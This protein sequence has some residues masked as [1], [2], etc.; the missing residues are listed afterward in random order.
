MHAADFI[1]DLAII[2]AVAG[3][4][5]V[6]F[7]RFKQPVV[8][9]YIVAGVIIG[10]HLPPAK[11]ITD[12]A[13]IKILGEL[14]VVF[15]LFSLGLEFNWRKLRQVGVT[16]F[17]GA[18]TEI[19]LMTWIGYEI[20]RYFEWQPIDALFLGAMLS[21]SSTTITVKAL[22]EL[23][24]KRERFAQLCFGI[25]IVEDILAIG[26]IALLSSAAAPGGFDPGL[27]MGTLLR[28]GVFL[29]VSLLLGIL[30]VPRLLAYVARFKSDEMLLISVLGISF[31]FCLL[32]IRLDYSVALGAFLIGAIM[33][34]ARELQTI[35]RLITPLRDMFS[36]IFFVAVGLLIDPKVLVEFAVPITVITTAVVIG[37]IVTR[38]IGTHLVG[39]SG[40]T[41]MR[42]GMTL[43]Q[44][45]EFSFIIAALGVSLKVT[46]PFLFPIAVA[47][48]AITTLFTPYL[49]RSAD[50]TTEVL[51]RVT[52]KPVTRV[53]A[54]YTEWL[55][56]IN[57]GRTRS[58][59]G[60][61]VRRILTHVLINFIVVV[62]IFL[63]GAFVA[64]SG[65][66][67]LDPWLAPGHTRKAIVW[68]AAC[69]LSLPFLV[70]AYRKCQA[71]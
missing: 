22:E 27:A 16:A 57:Q 56:A 35:E 61:W 12:E 45:G 15:L 41:S 50:R 36:A 42:V 37:K 34:E 60:A 18:L 59:M 28:L 24:L 48:S 2:M 20:G 63:A 68:G 43:A 53:L 9:G 38:A 3:L 14:G 39:H 69:L 17:V 19:V 46:S 64:G 13:T 8:L 5:T 11:L 70:A 65:R 6:L 67:W 66:E 7:H 51:D 10:P 54:L 52:P 31:A 32:V 33:A 47:V 71:L 30:I 62:A 23:G 49:I 44:I 29:V 58:Q 25:L 55:R 21:I 40:H 4:V 26:I 1:H